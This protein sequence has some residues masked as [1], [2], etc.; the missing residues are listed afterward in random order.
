ML[1]ETEDSPVTVSLAAQSSLPCWFVALQVYSPLSALVGLRSSNEDISCRLMILQF[2]LSL[3][4]VPDLNHLNCTFGASSISHSNLAWLPTLIS[5]GWIL[6]L[7]TGGTIMCREREENSTINTLAMILVDVV[8][9]GEMVNLGWKVAN[10]TDQEGLWRE[11]MLGL[12]QN[13]S[14]KKM[15]PR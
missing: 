10:R 7:K 1:K 6:Y 12:D 8:K 14:M 2:G 3:I 5:R 11:M 9:S 13:T 4:G 15:R